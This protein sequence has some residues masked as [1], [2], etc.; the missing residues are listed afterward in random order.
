MS[1]SRIV[2]PLLLAATFFTLGTLP[3]I[4]QTSSPDDSAKVRELE[5]RV[6]RLEAMVQTLVA[7]EQRAGKIP[8][9]QANSMMAELSIPG[10]P[11]SDL[12][13][14]A[15]AP[16]FDHGRKP[17]PQELLPNLGKIGATVSFTAGLN[18]GPF[19][20]NNGSYFGGAV[21]LPLALA[22]GGRLDYEIGI[23]LAQTSRTLPVTSGVAQVANLTVLNALNPTGGATN[24]QAAL[25]GSG[26]APFAVTASANWKAQV[27]QLTPFVLKYDLTTLDRYRIRPYAVVGLGT[28]VSLSSQNVAGSGL[29]SDS[30]LSAANLNLLST[31][32]GGTSPFGGSLVAG[33]VAPA[34][35][36]A[37]RKLPAGQ[38][39]V[40]LGIHFGGGVEWRI[41]NLASLGLD[42]RF[43][44]VPD[45]LS[46]H[47]IAAR[48][49]L[50]F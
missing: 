2:S 45:G 26:A 35:Q 37:E 20:L 47:T 23:A 12:P 11:V 25:T 28:Y 9:D 46:Y 14:S 21:D 29:R 33:Q 18:S 36:L 5:D 8:E 3:S 48:W 42:A 32:L 50:H 10:A 38:G 44:R 27:L 7:S 39:G 1:R 15:P 24:V 40:D 19:N 6:R 22:P 49:G 43:N 17:L 31:L 13:A 34:T 30:T 16:T 41:T 4:A